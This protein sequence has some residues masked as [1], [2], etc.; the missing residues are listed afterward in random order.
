MLQRARRFAAWLPW[1]RE[2]AARLVARPHQLGG[3]LTARRLFNLYL[4]RYEYWRGR[5]R[6]RSLP[7]RLVV[8][9]VSACNLRCPHC[10]TGAG[11]AGRPRALMPIELY[12]RLLAE[13]GDTLTELELFHWGEPLLHPEIDE[14]VR[15]AAERGIA[16]TINTNLAMALDADRA[17]R[18]IAS[19]L[20]EL[21]VAVDGTSQETYEQYRVRGNLAR[22]KDNCRRL[23]E[24]RRR[25]GSPTPRLNLE[26]H[27]FPHNA[28]D[29]PELGV[30][31]EELGMSLRVFKGVVP[32]EE[33]GKDASFEFCVNPIPVPCIFL[34]GTALVSSDGGCA[35][36][37]GA[38]YPEDDM[39]R[40]AVRPGEPGAA[41]FR[42]VWNGPRYQTARR[43]FRDRETT[44]AE[45]ERI[46]HDCPNTIMWERLRNHIA[47]GSSADRFDVGYGTNDIWNYFWNRRPSNRP[48]PA[49]TARRNAG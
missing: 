16:T 1:H 3:R 27:V 25:R 12:R 18:L 24:A 28:G 42:E 31:A 11:R 26:F 40:I 9:P 13:L 7:N 14:M 48:A 45:R 10:F 32:G 36:C 34:W 29:V 17:E 35:P 49:E 6:L 46:C 15:D 41:T 19:G 43:F 8:E 23:V 21:T 5:V 37:R 22:V 38:F 20:T 47:A 33:W 2:M 4:V 39:G 44:G 30:L